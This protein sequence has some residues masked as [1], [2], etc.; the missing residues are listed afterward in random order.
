MEIPKPKFKVKDKVYA[1][2]KQ[3]LAEQT[4]RAIY[5]RHYIDESL[6]TYGFEECDESYSEKDIISNYKSARK[7]LEENAT[8]LKLVLE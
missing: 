2:T 6:I 7:K 1:F 3:G 5:I 8:Q 4:I